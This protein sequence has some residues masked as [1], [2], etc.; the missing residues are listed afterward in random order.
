MSYKYINALV[1]ESTI[2]TDEGRKIKIFKLNTHPASAVIDEWANKFRQNY[3][4]DSEIDY[5]RG[6][7]GYSRQEYLEKIKFPNKDEGF[8]PGTRSGD[9]AELL[10]A[11]Y[12]QFV[13]NYYVPRTRYD[14]KVN[15]DSSTQGSDV[16]AFK[17]GEKASADD[18][19]VIYEVKCQASETNP[20]NKIQEAVDHSAKD[21]K[22]D[23]F[24]LNGIVQRLYDRRKFSDAEKV[25]RFQNPTDNPYK[26]LF[27]AVAVHSD[28]SYSEEIL[29]KVITKNHE[30][31]HLT[32]LAVHGEYLME[33]IH[34][35]YRRAAQC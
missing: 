32:L 24:S 7:Y 18:E 15:P 11:D 16:M 2:I 17:I 28:R 3:C 1:E 33:F 5:F 8:G 6:G 21:V 22:R 34:E 20:Q 13:R 29:K 4:V 27:G 19:L 26:E 14:R 30:S 25:K 12:L 31:P 23:A 10:V 35:L 9:F